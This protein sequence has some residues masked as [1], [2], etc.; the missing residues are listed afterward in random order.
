MMQDANAMPARSAWRRHA[1][2]IAIA[3][4]GIA[5]SA[6]A[7]HLAAEGGPGGPVHAPWA[8]LL[9]GLLLT[10]GLCGLQVRVSAQERR[11][12]EVERKHRDDSARLRRGTQALIDQGPEP[13][14]LKD[15][16]GRYVFCNRAFAG[17][18]G[19]SQ[20]D[21]AGRSDLD[22]FDPHTALAK[23]RRDEAAAGA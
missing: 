4:S 15:R 2:A 11:L 14:W 7:M 23:T 1:V 13:A 10:A 20:A 22:L 6:G 3:A 16:D 21:I 18:F 5:A 17:R 9:A 19:R 8:I 12:L